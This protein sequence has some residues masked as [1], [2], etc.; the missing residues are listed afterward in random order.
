MGLAHI[1]SYALSGLEAMPVRVEAHV[2]PGLPGMTIVGLPDAAVREAKERV[3]SAAVSSGFPLPSQ[4]ITLS[5][6]PGDLRKEGPGFDLPLALAA[7]AASGHIPHRNVGAV[8]AVG[9][10]GLNGVVRGMRGTL[11]IAERAAAEE[12]AGLIVPAAAVPEACQVCGLRVWGVR[13]LAEA[14]FVLRDSGRAD[15]VEMRTRRFAG[16]AGRRAADTQ[17]SGVD[18]SQVAGC[19][20]AKRGLEI[21][22][23]GGHHVLLVGSPGS[24]KTMLARRFPSIMPQLSQAESLEVTRIWSVCGLHG[25]GRSLIRTRPFRAPHHTASASALVGGGTYPRP[26]E[27]TLAHRGVLFLDELPEFARDSLEALRQPLEE[28]AVTVTRRNATVRFPA[29]FTLLAAMN[30]CPCE[31]WLQEGTG[32]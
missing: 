15:F 12:V 25:P 24:G 4:R 27:I 22:A 1:L 17:E 18:M 9:E 13:T 8:A 31:Y 2:R 6:S 19:R 23:I 7:L 20:H 21:A 5:L 3:R 28:G 32:S 14:V 16:R 10:V 26:G 30:P 11:A 29:R